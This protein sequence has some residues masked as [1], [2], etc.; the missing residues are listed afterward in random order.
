[1]STAQESAKGF[2]ANLKKTVKEDSFHVGYYG[3]YY[4]D[5]HRVYYIYL[6]NDLY[7]L[8]LLYPCVHIVHKSLYP[9]LLIVYFDIEN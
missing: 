6:Y 2:L 1:M 7:L 8:Y 3:I 4:L 9:Y 5:N